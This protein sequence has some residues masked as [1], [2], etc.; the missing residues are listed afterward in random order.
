MPR[1]LVDRRASAGGPHRGDDAPSTVVRVANRP[2]LRFPDIRGDALT[3][4]TDADVWMG[5]VERAEAWR[6]GV[7]PALIHNPR[8]SPDGATVAW[9]SNAAGPTEIWVAPVSGGEAERVTWWGDEGTTLMGWLRDGRLLAATAQG[10]WHAWDRWAWAVPLDGAPPQRLPWGPLSSLSEGEAGRLVIGVDQSM[11]RGFAWKRYRGGTAAKIWMEDEGEFR[12]LLPGLS[13]QL[14]DPQWWADR[15]VF[16]SDHEGWAN[17]YSVLPDGSDLRRHSDHADAYARS[18]RTDSRRLVYSCAGDL[19]LLD[20]L[21]PDSQPRSLEVRLSSP[22]RGRVPYPL[23]AVGA[24]RR[25]VPDRTGRA[26]AVVVRGAAVWLTHRDG[27]A[28]LLAPGGAVRARLAAPLG[29]ENVVWV[30]DAGGIDGL[31]ISAVAGGQSRR[32]AAGDLWVVDD[33]AASPDG[34]WVATAGADG[35]M[36][37]TNVE[38]GETREIDRSHHDAPRHPSWSPDSRW[39]AWSHAGANDPDSLGHLRQIRLAEV[40]TGRVVEAT[41]S[42]FADTEPVWTPDGRYLAFLSRRVFDPVYDQVRFDL[43]FPAATRPYLLRLEATSPAPLGPELAGR[44]VGDDTSPSDGPVRVAVDP[45]GLA[46]RLVDLPVAA[47][48]LSGLAVTRRGLV[49]LEHPSTGELGEG[50]VDPDERPQARVQHLDLRT[51]RVDTLVNAADEVAVTG[52]G[53]RL[54]VRGEGSVRVLPADRKAAEDGHETVEVDLGRILVTVDPAAEWPQM[55]VEAARLQR[56]LYWVEDMGGIDWDAVVTRYRP[57]ADRVSTRDELTDLLWEL[58]GELGTSHAYAM[59]PDAPTPAPRRHGYLGVDLSAEDGTWRIAAIPASEPSVRRARSPLGHAGAGVGDAVESVDGRPVDAVT[60]PGPLLVGA[61]NRIV[62]VGLRAVDGGAR[63]LAVRALPHEKE[64][65]YHA[66]VAANRSLVRERSG[67]R[68]GYVH[69]PN[70]MSLGWAQ[71][72]RDLRLESGRDGLIVDLRHNGGG[73]TSELVLERLSSA[74]TAWDKPR[75]FEP[76]RYP[77][78]A[79]LGP[80]AAVIDQAAGSD[81]DI[82]A[83]GFRQRRLGPLIGTRTWGGVVGIDGRYDLVDGG[84]VTQPR[85][86]FWFAGGAGWLVEGHGVDPDIDV[87]IAPHDW[88]AGRDPQLETAIAS[89]LA[90]VEQQGPVQPPSVNDRP[91][92]ALPALPP[93]PD[94]SPGRR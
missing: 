57:L 18:A 5:S 16:L 50:R 56:H 83:L 32:L 25:I 39:L 8:L 23:D 79:P 55:F 93:R 61:A 9:A 58:Q 62:E 53:E 43:G 28:R 88:A 65:R 76:A 81:G 91:S 14:E 49:W 17:V 41:P 34:A 37:L 92:R 82:G 11:S 1:S 36:R 30:S 15:V 19:W 12:R 46:E 3:F 89:V 42:R 24:V 75:G 26:S 27:P 66:W 86:A 78:D 4:V 20:S 21:A 84:R 7:G 59:P 64:L 90:S 22:R 6:L 69:I 47:G 94:T 60:G 70:M 74:V 51:G 10:A 71:L 87:P 52:D 38:S 48:R 31:E 63:R 2:Y 67:A 13:S 45:E 54:V 44:P 72:Q 29:G 33:L 35:A 73:H 80:M 40:A 68:L 85:Y 77:L